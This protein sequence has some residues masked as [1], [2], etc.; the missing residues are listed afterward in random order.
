MES[1]IDLL[2]HLVK[3][4]DLEEV[5][6]STV[7]RKLRKEH[8]EKVTEFMKVFKNA[9]DE[10]LMQDMDEAESLALME[11]LQAIDLKEK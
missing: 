10:A 9:F 1:R 7:M 4:A 3:S 11:A 2:R 5:G 6:Y 8:P